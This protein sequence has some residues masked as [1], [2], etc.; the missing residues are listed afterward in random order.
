MRNRLIADA[1]STK[2]DWTLIDAKGNS[3]SRITTEGLNALLATP[4]EAEELLRNAKE[5]L[6]TAIAPEDVPH[7]P[8][9]KKW[10]RRCDIYGIARM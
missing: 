7:R 4:A 8:F 10:K 2:T 9:A 1:G 5:K 6:G 3:I